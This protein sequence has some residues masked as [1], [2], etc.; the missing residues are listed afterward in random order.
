MDDETVNQTMDKTLT[1]ENLADETGDA[2]F[3]DNP[4]QLLQLINDGTLNIVQSG[5]QGDEEVAVDARNSPC[6]AGLCLS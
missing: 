6:T 5:S 1:K 4:E 2:P 3:I